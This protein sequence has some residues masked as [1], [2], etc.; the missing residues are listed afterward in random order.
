MSQFIFEG[1]TSDIHSS[2]MSFHYKIRHEGEELRFTENLILPNREV[3]S[4]P[5]TLL[6]ALLQTVH[7]VLGL[8][9]WKTYCPKEIIIEGYSLTPAQ[10]DFW[11]TVYTK[12]L[13]EFYYRN[14]IDFRGLVKFPFDENQTQTPQT[15]K[16]SNRYLIGVGGGKDSILSAEILKKNQINADGFVVETQK[17]YPLIETVLSSMKLDAIRIK[18]IIDPQLFAINKKEGVTNGHI[19]VSAVY[20][21]IGILTAALYGYDGLITSNER[22]ADYGNVEYLG[23]TVNHQWSKSREFETLFQTYIGKFISS[24][25]LYVSLLRPYSEYTIVELFSKYPEYFSSF[26]S[27]NRNFNIIEHENSPRWC[28]TCPKCAFVFALLS[29]HISKKELTDLFQTN[30]YA[31]ADLIPLYKELLGVSG[32]KPFE[33]VGTPDEVKLA[34]V[35]AASQGEYKGTPVMDLFEQQILPKLDITTLE[36]EVTNIDRSVIPE[37]FRTMI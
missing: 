34:M 2:V 35:K 16:K 31:Q 30:M 29:A 33:C 37:Q 22:S 23:E 17:S 24:D 11:N 6:H 8:S 7:I 32:F 1:Y 36:K 13:G 18:R 3:H 5:E 27:C 10:A 21:C 26:S 25:L 20:A 9:Y 19:P 12:G 14:E 4:I 15:M 28:G